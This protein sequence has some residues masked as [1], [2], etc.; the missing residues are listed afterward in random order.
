MERL[1]A[2]Q[3]LVSELERSG[4]RLYEQ[5]KVVAATELRKTLQEIKR[6]CQEA[7]KEALDAQKR[8]KE[9]N[10]GKRAAKSTTAE[11]EESA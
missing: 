11:V 2:I 8:L 5:N 10:K 9:E 1:S 3:N 4:N 6:E 7:R